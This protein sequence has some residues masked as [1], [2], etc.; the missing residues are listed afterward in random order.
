VRPIDERLHLIGERV[1]EDRKVEAWILAFLRP[2]GP[3]VGLLASL[4]T[5]A[6]ERYR[7]FQ[8]LCPTFQLVP[9][10]A[11]LLRAAGIFVSP[12]GSP[13]T[14]PSVPREDW[15]HSVLYDSITWDGRTH[16]LTK[17]EAAVVK[18]LDEARL[19]GHPVLSLREI[20]DAAD[21][22]SVRRLRDL[23]SER[24]R[25]LLR[26][27]ITAEGQGRYRLKVARTPD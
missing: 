14:T 12:S 15:S 20:A 25:D 23:L 22:L 4:P 26:T 10:D 17:T 13:S 11:A 27:L 21:R 6:G 8:V 3:S 19:S 24:N 7:R 16:V 18:A 9:T 1:T 2:D 5:L